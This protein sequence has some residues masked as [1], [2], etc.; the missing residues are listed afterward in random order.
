M[1]ADVQ[2]FS[3]TNGLHSTVYCRNVLVNGG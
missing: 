3:K 2:F 1:V